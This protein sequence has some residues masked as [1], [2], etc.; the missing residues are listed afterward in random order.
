[1]SQGPEPRPVFTLLHEASQRLVRTVDALGDEELAEASLLPG[2]SR[3]HVAAHLA[4]N[5]EALEGVLNGVRTDDPTPMYPSQEA[6]DAAIEELAA[7]GPEEVRHRILSSVT[8][9]AEA[10][11]AFPQERSEQPVERVPGG[12]TFPAGAALPMRWREVELHHADLGAGYGRAD[13]PEE[14]PVALIADLVAGQGPE[15]T[16]PR[17]FRMLARDVAR[18][19]DVG[20]GEITAPRVVV[21]GD[22]ADLAWWLSGRG[23]GERLHADHGELPEVP[24]W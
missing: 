2:W 14:F 5:A 20:D 10:A 4:C 9:F 15:R 22:A 11:A 8:R 21:S 17:P 7:A 13:W 12:R 18:T 6:R 23:S 16:W 19:W 3:A 24:A 1:M